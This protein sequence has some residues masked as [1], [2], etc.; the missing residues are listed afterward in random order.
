MTLLRL[1]N[2]QRRDRV[3]LILKVTKAVDSERE[4]D[5]AVAGNKESTQH[6]EHVPNELENMIPVGLREIQGQYLVQQLSIYPRMGVVRQKIKNA[7]QVR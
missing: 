7:V 5:A 4:V 6:V 2:T 3:V 1:L